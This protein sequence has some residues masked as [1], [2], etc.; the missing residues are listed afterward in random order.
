M[1]LIPLTALAVLA[2]W[3]AFRAWLRRRAAA[4]RWHVV[5]RTAGDGTRLVVLAGPD[6]RERVVRELPAAMDGAALESALLDARSKAFGEALRLNA[7]PAPARA[8]A[9]RIRS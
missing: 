8:P 3:L 7:P 6:G 9:P 2:I 1:L 5:T 4:G